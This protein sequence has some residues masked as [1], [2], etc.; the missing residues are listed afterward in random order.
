MVYNHD[1]HVLPSYTVPSSDA[2]V[3]I[4]ASVF[5]TPGRVV[6]SAVTCQPCTPVPAGDSVGT[7]A[8]R[9]HQIA[10]VTD[11]VFTVNTEMLPMVCR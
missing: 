2:V 10:G 3:G 11:A 5:P 8:L 4:R 1:N 6:A 7:V 9:A